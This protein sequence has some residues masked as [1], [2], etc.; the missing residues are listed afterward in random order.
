MLKSVQVFR[1]V[2]RLHRVGI[3]CA[4][5][6]V[7]GRIG[8]IVHEG[9]RGARGYEYEW[10][11]RPLAAGHAYSFERQRAWLGPY[12]T[13]LDYLP[14][15]WV[16][17]LQTFI[18][19]ACFWCFGN[20]GGL[21]LV[22]L[23]VL[24]YTGTGLLIYQCCRRLAGQT[25]AIVAVILFCGLI[26][27]PGNLL[28]YI[29]NVSLASLLFMVCLRFLIVALDERTI[30][31]AI[32]LGVVIGITNLAH[33]GSSLFGP[34]AACL[35]LLDDRARSGGAGIR[36]AAV[37]VLSL[38]VVLPWTVRNYITFGELIPVRT[39]MGL[40]LNI[41]N[42]ALASTV[43]SSQSDSWEGRPPWTAPTIRHAVKA[44]RNIHRERAVR[45][46]AIDRTVATAP[47]EYKWY[48]EAQRDRHFAS[49]AWSFIRGNP[50]TAFELAVWKSIDFLFGWGRKSAVIIICA[51]AGFVLHYHDL[52]ALGAF[53][54][55]A[56]Y[57]IPYGLS[58][59]VYYR[60][61]A[62]MEP[63]ICVG[64]ALFV[65]WT[66]QRLSRQKIASITQVAR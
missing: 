47:P 7:L 37:L 50:W 13:P 57:A 55:L 45:Y 28:T 35:V 61:R 10:I 18:A 32:R 25:P 15:A 27:G 65:G 63:L 29:G 42:P 36:A 64:V 56:V 60:Y 23:N 19:A 53:L 12:A 39:G 30:P 2:T 43:M 52:R 38:A 46:F 21:A 1:R 33:A 49:A 51:V 9:W 3:G 4:G 26:L 31:S 16:E 54:F 11:A 66:M 58:L 5:L 44:M 24:W 40:M 59:P 8:V 20:A 6:L 62:P 48:N 17:P 14:T 41:G 34:V 22:L